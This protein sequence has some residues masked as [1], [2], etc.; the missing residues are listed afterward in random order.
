MTGALRPDGKPFVFDPRGK[1]PRY[2]IEDDEHG[3]A[4]VVNQFTGWSEVIGGR[5]YSKDALRAAHALLLRNEWRAANPG[6]VS[7]WASNTGAGNRADE[8]A[9]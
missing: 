6:I 7:A 9:E 4:L 1:C 8:D 2:V 5:P 3:T